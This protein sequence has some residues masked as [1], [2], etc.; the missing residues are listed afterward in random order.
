MAASPVLFITRDLL[1]HTRCEYLF[2]FAS[3]PRKQLPSIPEI[4]APKSSSREDAEEFRESLHKI[5]IQ[6]L[7]YKDFGQSSGLGI[8][9]NFFKLLHGCSQDEAAVD[10]RDYAES[11]GVT[12]QR[13]C[14][15]SV[16]FALLLGMAGE[17]A[18]LRTVAQ[19]SELKKGKS[20]QIL[21]PDTS[22]F[23]LPLLSEEQQRTA[24]KR[25]EVLLSGLFQN[26]KMTSAC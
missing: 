9:T 15:N 10:L 17:W 7:E 18:L 14:D 12:P 16:E 8:I 20:Y 6:T 3:Y 19:L 22:S 25:E 13:P 11:Q 26:K 4:A 24:L 21:M 2:E 5:L 1:P 23:T